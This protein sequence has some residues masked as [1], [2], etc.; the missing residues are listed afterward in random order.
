MQFVTKE[1]I[2][3]FYVKFKDKDIVELN[4]MIEVDE[5]IRIVNEVQNE[6]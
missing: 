1:Q 4:E 3:Q 6:R 2:D 5:I